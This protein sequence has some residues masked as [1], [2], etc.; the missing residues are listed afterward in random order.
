MVEGSYKMRNELI[1]TLEDMINGDAI[2]DIQ[3]FNDFVKDFVDY[4]EDMY[5]M[6]PS[7]VMDECGL[8]Y[9]RGRR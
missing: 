3:A 2:S 8:V 7:E 5:G 1:K 6:E 4:M 9:M